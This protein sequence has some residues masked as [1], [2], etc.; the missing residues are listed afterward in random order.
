MEDRKE[1]SALKMMM[2]MSFGRLKRSVNFIMQSWR[3]EYLI[4][5]IFSLLVMVT[6]KLRDSRM[7]G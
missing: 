5:F 4:E 2:I 6:V 1:L 7:N 3:A